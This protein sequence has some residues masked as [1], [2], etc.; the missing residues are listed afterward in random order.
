M[1]EKEIKQIDFT[2]IVSVLWSNRKK[3]LVFLPVVLVGTY[4]CT[5]TIPRFYQCEVSLAPESTNSSSGSLNSL[6]SSFGLGSLA[7]I[8]GED[9]INVELYPNILSS[10]DF[11]AT[12]MP[13]NI[14]TQKGDIKCNY[15]TYLKDKQKCTPWEAISAWIKEKVK[16]TPPDKYD[17][18]EKIKVFNLTKL[19]SGIFEHA[20]GNIKCSVDK[21][22][23]V[24]TISVKDQDPL[25]CA[26]IANATCEKLQEFIIN[27]R[28]KKARIDFDFYKKLCAEAKVRY[29]RSR[30]RFGHFSDSNMD[31]ILQSYKSKEE[32]LENE[33]QL[34]YNAYSSVTTQMQAA[35]AKLQEATP[36]FT[37]LQSASV[38]VKP[39]GPKRLF[40][41]IGMMLLSFI[42]ISIWLANKNDCIIHKSSK[43]S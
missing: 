36:A 4:L 18:K 16:P 38:P 32:D 7:K 37:I 14:K 2:K 40:I 35:Q 17:G 20:K 9:A 11:I 26:I 3:Y 27:Y 28:T 12:L 22:T 41:S 5:L 42:A 10:N 15:Y 30:Q 29:E 24:A 33:M 43:L 1:K 19:Q 23:G 34:E 21:K 31:V 6:A 25:V 8:A 13:I 39:A